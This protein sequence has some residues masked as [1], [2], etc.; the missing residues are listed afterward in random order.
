MPGFIQRPFGVRTGNHRRGYHFQ[1]VVGSAYFCRIV[2]PTLSAWRLLRLQ[3]VFLPLPESGSSHGLSGFGTTPL[4]SQISPHILLGQNLS[5]L[6]IRIADR[7]LVFTEQAF[8][9]LSYPGVKIS[10]YHRPVRLTYHTYHSLFLDRFQPSEQNHPSPSCCPAL[11]RQHPLIPPD[12]I[13]LI[14]KN[15]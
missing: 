8:S 14:N 15:C 12:Y 13:R 6:F 3:P 4:P 9:M 2:V 1:L 11:S 10:W 7:L 5:K